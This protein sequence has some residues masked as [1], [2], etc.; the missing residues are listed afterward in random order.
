MPQ[1]RSLAFLLLFDWI[2][3]SVIIPQE[4][5]DLDRFMGRWYEVA[6]VSDCP[7]Y[8]QNKRQNPVIVTLDLKLREQGNINVLVAAPRNGSCK[9]TA[10]HFTLTD[11]GGQFF[12]HVARHNVDVDAYVVH[13]NYDHYAMMGLLSMEVSSQNKSTIFKLFNRSSDGRHAA[14]DDFKRLVRKHE[15]R[16]DNIIFNGKRDSNTCS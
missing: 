6:V 10:T 15:M 7:H 16:D 4:N 14:L 3:A 9:H 2:G 11:V 1:M 8:M 13:T 5:F 12:C